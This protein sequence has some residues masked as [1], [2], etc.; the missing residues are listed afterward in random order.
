MKL[1]RGVV[2]HWAEAGAAVPGGGGCP[3]GGRIQFQLGL[4]LLINYIDHTYVPMQCNCHAGLNPVYPA[5]LA[6]MAPA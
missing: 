1:R 4:Q 5:G 3:G 6:Q 2:V